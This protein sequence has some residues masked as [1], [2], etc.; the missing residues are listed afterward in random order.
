MDATLRTTRIAARIRA[1]S[2]APGACALVL[3]NVCSQLSSCAA[4]TRLLKLDLDA[5]LQNR[6][7]GCGRVCI[8]ERAAASPYFDASSSV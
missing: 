1:F 5:P 6:Q 3:V 4:G 8:V 2:V 7:K